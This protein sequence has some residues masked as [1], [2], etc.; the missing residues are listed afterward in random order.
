VADVEHPVVS[1]RFDPLIATGRPFRLGIMGGTFDPIHH[2]H[3]VCAQQALEQFSL[4]GV[5]FMVT[6]MSPFKSAM[7]VSPAADRLA[8]VRC[9]VEK[10]P[11]FDASAF[12]IES[13][14]IS[15]TARTL[16]ALHKIYPSTVEFFFIT[17]ADAILSI[18]KWKDSAQLAQLTHF[19]AATRPGYPLDPSC[20]EAGSGAFA[21]FDVS[22]MEVP[23]LAISSTQLRQRIASGRTIRYLTPSSVIEYIDEHGLYR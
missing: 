9:A 3:L 4:D 22:Y 19:I 5:L 8:M 10:N 1:S 11:S 7:E 6:G 23:L 16:T 15:Y 18:L 14:G 12:E 2:G 20:G 17:G 13:G 21:A